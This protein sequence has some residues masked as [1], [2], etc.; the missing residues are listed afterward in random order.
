MTAQ[1][2]KHPQYGLLIYVDEYMYIF[3]Q[4]ILMQTYYVSSSALS[5]ENLQLKK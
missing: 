5:T 4:E 1:P 2:P 3:I